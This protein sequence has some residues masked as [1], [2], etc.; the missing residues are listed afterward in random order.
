MFLKWLKN[1]LPILRDSILPERPYSFTSKLHKLASLQ[2]L[3]M[4]EK[5]HNLVGVELSAV[6]SSVMVVVKAVFMASASI[7][8]V[9]ASQLIRDLLY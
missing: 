2:A 7:Q 1:A 3:F 8:K 4:A 6:P 9:S 5:E